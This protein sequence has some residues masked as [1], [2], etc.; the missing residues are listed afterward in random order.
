MG[1]I[2]DSMSVRRAA[3][4]YGIPRLTLAWM[5]AVTPHNIL[6]GFEVTGIYP[7]NR[8]KL[9]PKKPPSTERTGLFIPLLTPVRHSLVPTY[10]T[11]SDDVF[12]SD[13]LESNNDL[14]IPTPMPIPTPPLQSDSPPSFQTHPSS[15][16]PFTAEEILLFSKR[17]EEGYDISTDDRYNYWLS[18]ERNAKAAKQELPRGGT[19]RG[20]SEEYVEGIQTARGRGES[21]KY[22]EEIQT[23][24]GRGRGRA[25]R[26]NLT[27][28]GNGESE[29][30]VDGIQ[31]ARGRDRAVRANLTDTG[32]GESEEYVEG[33]QTA[34]GRGR[35]RGRAVKVRSMLEKTAR[36]RGRGRAVRVNLTDTGNGESEEYVEGIQTARGRGRRRGRA[37]RANLTDTG[38]GE[39]E[40]YVEGI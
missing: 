12:L 26:A 19:A 10:D 33:I 8:Y 36:G 1:A 21:E 37:V 31:T 27:D 11:Y 5:K 39:S 30:Y 14:L 13:K 20:E 18:L 17:K 29:E 35:G 23:A 34:R 7:I 16:A 3:E 32:I 2:H 9:L 38:N 4:E 28:T 25:V 24:R 40:E 15:V 22:V 6:K